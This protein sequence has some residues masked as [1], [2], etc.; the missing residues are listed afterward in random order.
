VCNGN[1]ARRVLRRSAFLDEGSGTSG[2]DHPHA[3]IRVGQRFLADIYHA[4][5]TSPS[6]ART[7]LVITYDEWGGFFD[8]VPPPVAPDANPKARLR[9]FRVPNLVISP[10]ARRAHIAHD[11]YDHTSVVKAIEWRFGLPPLTARDAA[12]R[13][14]AE[15]LDFSRPPN[16]S[17]PQW[18]VPPAAGF[19]CVSGNPGDYE[20]WT[21]LANRAIAQGWKLT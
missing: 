17:A 19:A 9:G 18:R 1:P 14:L 16:L 10:R 2:D 21:A 8:H 13:N 11:V 12:A 5:T 4:V 7:L 20:E 3:D 6:W 15:V